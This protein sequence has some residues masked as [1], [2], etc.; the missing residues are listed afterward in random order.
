MISSSA[1]SLLF[2]NGQDRIQLGH[3]WCHARNYVNNKNQFRDRRKYIHIIL[4]EIRSENK[5]DL[6]MEE[7][8]LC[9]CN[10]TFGW[11]IWSAHAPILLIFINL[12]NYWDKSGPSKRYSA[13]ID[14][15]LYQLEKNFG[16]S[17]FLKK[18]STGI[19]LR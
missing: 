18:P 17:I 15:S 3:S 19:F 13:V 16:F 1:C 5:N 11:T 2:E 10:L 14:M 8:Y 12:Q 4:W 9:P 7:K 6:H